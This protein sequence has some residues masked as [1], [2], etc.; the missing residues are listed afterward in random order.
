MIT[1]KLILKKKAS[2]MDNIRHELPT[3][4]G[5]ELGKGLTHWSIMKEVTGK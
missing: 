3:A 4:C 1:E 2:G 5:N